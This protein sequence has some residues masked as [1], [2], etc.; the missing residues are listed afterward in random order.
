[1]KVKLELHNEFNVTPI[2]NVIGTINGKE[3]PDRYVLMGNH[4]D[5]WVFGGV[6]AVSG[7]STTTEIARGLGELLKK[8]WRPRRTIK[9]CSWGGEEYGLIGSFEYV[10]HNAK[11]L[12]N[13]GMAYL[14][15]DIPV[16]GNWVAKIA[17]SPLLKTVAESHEKTIHDPNAH[18]DKQSIYDIMTERDPGPNGMA[19][20]PMVGSGSDFAHFYHYVGVPVMDFG[21]SFGYNNKSKFYPVYHTQHDTY[22]W[23]KT[24]IDPNFLFHKA[25]AEL[26]A[27]ILLDVADSPILPFNVND[28][29]KKLNQSFTVL[30]SSEYIKN[31]SISLDFLEEAVY[32]F[33]KAADSFSKMVDDYRSKQDE[34]G[35][36]KLRQINDQLVQVDTLVL[37]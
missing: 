8:G 26:S 34:I 22:Y 16:E 12:T 18:D 35:F 10:E 28:Y 5:A 3:E 20:Y 2:Y 30:K 7:T 36:A 31:H 29:T 17:G 11:E 23:I 21:Y 37:M 14:N 15:M 4:R 32:D 19:R 1:M 9:M 24:F 6:D 33:I 27:S 13:K 25:M